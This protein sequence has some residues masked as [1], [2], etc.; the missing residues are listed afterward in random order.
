MELVDLI[1]AKPGDFVQLLNASDGDIMNDG[2]DDASDGDVDEDCDACVRDRPRIDG[3]YE[4]YDEYGEGEHVCMEQT[5]PALLVQQHGENETRPIEV[6]STYDLPRRNDLPA[7]AALAAAR[8]LNSPASPL[9][10]L[11]LDRIAT[12]DA[13]ERILEQ[14]NTEGHSE[15]MQALMQQWL[16]T[17]A[18]RDAV[19]EAAYL[20]LNP[21]ETGQLFHARM[22]QTLGRIR[23]EDAPVRAVTA[24]RVEQAMQSLSPDAEDAV[25]RL[26]ALGFERRCVIEAYL[27]C[28]GDE[29]LAANFLI[30]Q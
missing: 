9:P 5:F 8:D 13:G 17:S 19:Q 21:N 29:M 30:D 27:A 6:H 7:G 3:S 16:H 11:R 22:L 20:R 15:L 2:L 12:A 23:L 28:N 25:E 1:A 26:S 18:G 24:D 4:L 10:E 14:L